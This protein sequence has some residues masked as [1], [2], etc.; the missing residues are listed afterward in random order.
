MKISK[1]GLVVAVIIFITV[2]LGG[3][4][5]A[6]QNQKQNNILSQKI[7]A[8]STKL[9]SWDVVGVST[10]SSDSIASNPA[11]KTVASTRAVLGVSDNIAISN[12]AT[13]TPSPSILA[14]K[15]IVKVRTT[16][17]S[18]RTSNPEPT[19]IPTPTVTQVV[20]QVTVEIQGQGT[21][22]VELK[23][24][25]NAYTVLARA[26]SENNFTLNTID[27]GGSLGIMITGIGGVNAHDNYFWS[28]YYNGVASMVGASS[29]VVNDGDATSWKY[30]T[31]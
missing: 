20:K 11:D 19:P 9:A 15:K 16:P 8:I 18:D 13:P 14:I 27:Y 3:W 23:D 4:I 10:S 29:Q 30:E 2:S 6:N 24:G 5:L 21:Y 17:N 12:T 1:K 22:K 26:A 7:D 31:W 25:D 28:F